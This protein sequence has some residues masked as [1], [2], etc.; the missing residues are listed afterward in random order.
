MLMSV[1]R[2]QMIL[3]G[4]LDLSAAFD[5]D[6][7]TIMIEHLRTHSEFKDLPYHGLFFISDS[8]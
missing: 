6:Y 5:I 7:H 8:T 3:L 1:N 4:L 2:G